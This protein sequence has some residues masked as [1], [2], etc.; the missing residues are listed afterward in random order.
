MQKTFQVAF[1]TLTASLILLV[2]GVPVNRRS[3]SPAWKSSAPI[4]DGIPMPPPPP[5]K[6]TL[7]VVVA[8]GIP[9]PPPPPKKPTSFA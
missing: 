1:V 8:D 6:P 3:A 2:T 7:G 5:K 4:A 9:M